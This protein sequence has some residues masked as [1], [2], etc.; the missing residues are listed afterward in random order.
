MRKLVSF[1]A[2]TATVV[3]Y[4]GCGRSLGLSADETP[5][6]FDSRPPL[7]DTYAP[8][9]DGLVPVDGWVPPPRDFGPPPDFWTPTPD[10]GPLPDAAPPPPDL[11][12]RPDRWVPPWPDTGPRP[13]RWVPPPPDR[14]VKPDRWVPP[15]P[16]TGPN[17][18]WWT[19]PPPDVG[20]TP[21]GTPPPPDVG[22]LPDLPLPPDQ[23]IPLPDTGP[24]SA[25]CSQMCQVVVACGLYSGTY[26]KCVTECASWP[27]SQLSCLTRYLC[28]GVSSCVTYGTCM[29][30]QKKPDLTVR[31]FAAKV[32]GSTVTY[33]AQVC[34]LGQGDASGFYLDVYYNRSSA[35]AVKQSGDKYIV[36][37]T[38][39]AGKCSTHTFTRPNTPTGTYRSYIQVDSDASVSESNESN[40][41]SGPITVKVSKPPPV[42]KP[43]LVISKVTATAGGSWSFY[44]RYRVTVCNNGSVAAGA[45]RLDV[46]LNRSSAPKVNQTGDRATTLTSLNPGQCTT[47]DVNISRVR[48]G[49]YTSYAQVDTLDAVSESTETNNTYGPIKVT[50]GTAP[51]A[52]LV[53]RSLTYNPYAFNTVLYRVRVCN[54]GKGAAGANRVCVYYNR[55]SAPTTSTRCDQSASVPILQ[56]G[57]CTDRN[58]TRLA[59]P[60]GT[61]ASWA[62]VDYRRQV[63]ETNENNN[64]AGPLKV[65]M[66]G[67]ATKPD[68]YVASFSGKVSGTSIAY[69]ARVCN[70]GKVRATPFRVDFY[71]DRSSAPSA[72]QYGDPWTI[73]ATLSG[74]SCTNVSRTVNN[75]RRGRTYRSYV[76]V[77]TGDWVSEAAENNNVS[78]PQSFAIANTNPLTCALSC[79]FAIQCGLFKTSEL[80]ICINWC[81]KLSA[82]QA[83]CVQSAQRSRSCSALKKCNLPPKPAPP[84]ACPSLCKWFVNTCKLLPSGQY[85]VCLGTCGGLS[86]SKLS[87]VQKAQAANQCNQA[88]ICLL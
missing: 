20:P 51:G 5:P 52:D 64:T 30:T 13:D 76:Q 8:P 66:G 29:T 49:T 67:A 18:D 12:P 19:P 45:S 54:A 14:G 39:K 71:P 15:P 68:L 34:N 10:V 85:N 11:R 48:T 28:A 50:V 40:N 44:I 56:P 84:T 32:S 78:G 22:P 69:T 72:K 55:S 26:N 46:Y 70:K 3:V 53:I 27:T 65:T 59:A 80:P 81:G 41:V 36:V 61:Y 9:P 7:P 37:P 42:K 4:A 6:E 74:G 17:Q 31:N 58:V 73:V 57:Q 24:C 35:P 21:D 63:T 62:Y 33:Q 83:S 47:R 88:L 79:V 87:C 75:L 25:T 1:L 38:L 77:D 16:D 23:G 43:D 82:S 2:L 86:S 60:N